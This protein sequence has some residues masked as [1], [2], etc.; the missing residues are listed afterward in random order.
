MGFV[1][2][3]SGRMEYANSIIWAVIVGYVITLVRNY[4]EFP[5]ETVLGILAVFTLFALIVANIRARIQYIEVKG[6]GLT[7]H[8]GLLNKRVMFIP[9]GRIT[10]LR[11]NRG[12]LERIFMLGSVEVDTAGTNTVEV[13]MGNIPSHYLGRLQEAVQGKHAMD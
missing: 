12:I 7:V 5:M 10:N 11:I 1:V 9:Y 13:V 6:E 8:K 3:C 2:R 4:V